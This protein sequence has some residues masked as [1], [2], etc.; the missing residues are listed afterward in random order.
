MNTNLNSFEIEDIMV[1]DMYLLIL[2]I[3]ITSIGSLGRNML[4]KSKK[5]KPSVV[6]SLVAALLMSLLLFFSSDFLIQYLPGKLFLFLATICGILS[7]DIINKISTLQ[8]LKEALQ[9]IIDL[10]NFIKNRK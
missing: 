9:F 8:G 10:M 2:L 1:N 7:I 5:Y 4:F 6:R 3:T